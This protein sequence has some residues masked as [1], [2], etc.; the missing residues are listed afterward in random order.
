MNVR[1]RGIRD[2]GILPKE[3][4]VLQ[5]MANA[6]I[7][8]YAVFAGRTTPN[9]ATSNVVLHTYWFPD[10]RVQG[11]ELVVLYTKVGKN[12]EKM[13]EDGLLTYFFYWG[14]DA[15]LWADSRSL[16]ILLEVKDWQAHPGE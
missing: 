4:L 6:D 13:T 1:I 16:P 3:R 2:K 12:T 9:G 15:P 10:R 14:K 8:S 5:V 7:G 11:S